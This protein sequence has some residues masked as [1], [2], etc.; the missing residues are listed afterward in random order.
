MKVRKLLLLAKRTQNPFRQTVAPDSRVLLIG[1]PKQKPMPQLIPPVSLLSLFLPLPAELVHTTGSSLALVG[2]AGTQKTALL[3]QAAVRMVTVT[4]PHASVLF[5]AAD[6]IISLPH[7][8]HQMPVV[9]ISNAQSIEIQYFDSSGDL[10]KYLAEYHQKDTCPR[11]IVIDDLHKFAQRKYVFGQE[12]D[13]QTIACKI[14]T[15]ARELAAFCGQRS[16]RLCYLMVGCQETARIRPAP[17]SLS[18]PPGAPG[19]WD[20][21][22]SLIPVLNNFVENVVRLKRHEES[23]TTD[24]M[25]IHMDFRQY[26]ICIYV[27]GK[28]IFVDRVEENQMLHPEAPVTP[29]KGT[30]HDTSSH[31]SHPSPGDKQSA[32]ESVPKPNMKL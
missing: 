29:D 15:L 16:G 11:A 19:D 30:G 12:Y 13:P 20:L 10:I 27:Q 18:P 25:N 28:Q 14:L 32:G 2:P 9:D 6:P 4:D 5:V 24:Q 3:M 17:K 1:M 31:S 21:T 7:V 22:E 26:H 8:V 23:E